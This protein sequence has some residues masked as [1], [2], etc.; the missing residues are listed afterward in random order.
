MDDQHGKEDA[1]E[2]AQH[3]AGKRRGEGDPAVIDQASLGGRVEEHDGLVELLGDLMR[4]RQDR[5]DPVLGP[6]LLDE[7]GELRG[8]PGGDVELAL[9]RRVEV[10][11]AGV[12]DGEDAEGDDDDRDEAA[13]E[14]ASDDA[15]AARRERIGGG[16][17]AACSCEP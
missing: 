17:H 14:E 5:A 12:P 7:L 1:E 11:G 15:P 13:G 16:G 2:G 6:G 10:G 4:R 3:E 9:E 8:P